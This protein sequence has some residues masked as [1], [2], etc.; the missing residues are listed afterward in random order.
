MEFQVLLPTPYEHSTFLPDFLCLS[1]V[2][3]TRLNQKVG[4]G[5]RKIFRVPFLVSAMVLLLIN[6]L[7]IVYNNITNQYNNYY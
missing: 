5:E 3:E 2:I 1:Q 4:R 6:Y 7:I